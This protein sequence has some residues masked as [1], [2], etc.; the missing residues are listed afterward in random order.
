MCHHHHPRLKYE[1]YIARFPTP[2]DLHTRLFLMSCYCKDRNHDSP[3]YS[4]HCIVFVVSNQFKNNAYLC[5]LVLLMFPI[6]T[7]LT[8]LCVQ[9]MHGVKHISTSQSLH[10]N[11]TSWYKQS[12]QNL[13]L[14]FLF[15]SLHKTNYLPHLGNQIILSECQINSS[16]PF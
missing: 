10:C 15:S 6:I 4:H 5:I 7:Q 13:E 3:V 16:L 9:Y 2:C 11:M 8:V 1:N 12:L 14:S